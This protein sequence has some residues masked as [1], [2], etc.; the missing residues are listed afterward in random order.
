MEKENRS[1]ARRILGSM[2]IQSTGH[3]VLKMEPKNA[4]IENQ[5]GADKKE[6]DEGKS[7]QEF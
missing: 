4:T 7:H 3:A 6:L 5:E 2:S 1:L